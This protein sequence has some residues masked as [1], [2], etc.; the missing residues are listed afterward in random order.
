MNLRLFLVI[1]LFAINNG[2][3][4]ASSSKTDKAL[5]A[6]SKSAASSAAST[7]SSA[8]ASA[9]SAAA[10]TLSKTS[11]AKQTAAKATASTQLVEVQPFSIQYDSSTQEEAQKLYDSLGGVYMALSG[12]FVS[13]TGTPY[14]E[15]TCLT[16][17]S[18]ADVKALVGDR[19]QNGFPI[20]MFPALGIGL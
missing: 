2:I 16:T 10:N 14:K 12:S 17:K 11:A 3:Y 9:A 15:I 1:G 4:C 8:A 6:Q 7:S 5:D 20:L 13:H 18:L 19:K